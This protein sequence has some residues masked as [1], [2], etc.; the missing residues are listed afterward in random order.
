MTTELREMIEHASD[1][2][3][4]QFR[5]SGTI[6]PIYH[7]VTRNDEQLITGTPHDDKDVAVAMIRALFALQ[8]VVRYVF[9][10]EAWTLERR[11][12]P[13]PAEM[14][15]IARHGLSDHP[16]RREVV[17]FFAEDNRGNCLQAHR[18]ILRPQHGRATLAPL[19]VIDMTN[20]KSTGRMV[21]LLMPDQGARS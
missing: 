13:S 12:T 5:K 3:D 16:D 7:A 10:N 21:G 20:A 14:E 18:C 8:D 11:P 2:A 15:E 4:K 6:L 1:W 17:M 9:V 19:H